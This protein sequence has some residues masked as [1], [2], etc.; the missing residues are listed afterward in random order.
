MTREIL[1]PARVHGRVLLDESGAD[2]GSLRLLVG[3]HGYAQNA[4]EMLAELQRIPGHD[5]WTLIAVQALNRFYRGRTHVTVANWMTRQDRERQIADN[6]TY[7]DGAIDA[8]AGT[9]E[10]SAL[11]YCGFSQ[12]VAMAFRAAA[13]GRRRADAVLALG[14]DVP[15]ELLGDPSTRF[16]HVVLAAGA[17]DDFYTPA[18]MRADADALTGRT[19]RVETVAFDAGH[20]WHDAFR[21]HAAGVLARLR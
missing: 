2:D 20:E 19:E 5:G 1:A 11:V 17:R 8:A 7:V 15:P 12:G 14:G 9:R 4:D 10:V 13:L 18:R 16:P 6:V 3:F 21:R